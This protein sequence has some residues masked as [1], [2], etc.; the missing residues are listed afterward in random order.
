MVRSDAPWPRSSR[1]SAQSGPR[2]PCSLAKNR[3]KSRKQRAALG[4]LRS[5]R[6]ERPQENRSTTK[7]N[8]ERNPPKHGKSARERLA[9]QGR[10]SRHQALACLSRVGEKRPRDDIAAATH[11]RLTRSHA[12][13]PKAAHSLNLTQ[14]R[15]G[16]GARGS[17]LRTQAVHGSIN[18]NPSP[19]KSP[20]FRVASSK[21]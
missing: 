17:K 5:K 18:A 16:G 15:R 8:T 13:R 7:K 11:T 9:D 4:R 2:F 21:S 6:V 1:Y 14:A 20:T 19:L 10:K 3:E 12:V